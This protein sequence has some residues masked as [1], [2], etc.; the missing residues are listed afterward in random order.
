MLQGYSD[1]P[2]LAQVFKLERF[3]TDRLGRQTYEVRFGVT[4]LPVQIA[5]AERLLV[6]AR[7]EGD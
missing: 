6:I 3:V 7:S 4:S 1:W 2:Y 5:T